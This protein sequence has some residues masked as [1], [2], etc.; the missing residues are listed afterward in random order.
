MKLVKSDGR[1]LEVRDLSEPLYCLSAVNRPF[2]L[3]GW[4]IM[5]DD[6]A[7]ELVRRV[8]QAQRIEAPR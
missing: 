2:K 6:E 3:H 8:A 4:R 5:P 7:R 1:N